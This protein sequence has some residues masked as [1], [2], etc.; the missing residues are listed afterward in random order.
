M[1]RQ[2]VDIDGIIYGQKV[3]VRVEALGKCPLP[4]CGGWV[5]DA[6]RTKNGEPTKRINCQKFFSKDCDFGIWK[7]FCGKKLSEEELI[8]LLD[9]G[10]T[11]EPVVGLKS[12]KGNVFEAKLILDEYDYKVRLHKSEKE[13]NEADD[14]SNESTG[15]GSE[16]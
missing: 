4:N 9:E 10:I 2:S 12:Q 3:K 13:T 8:E 7:E 1:A 5:I 6:K 14:S 11:K 15:D 16:E